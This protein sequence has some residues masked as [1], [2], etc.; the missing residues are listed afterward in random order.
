MPG[1]L[2]SKGARELAQLIRSGEVSSREVI[3]A[4][5]ERISEVNLRVNAVVEV[6]ETSA[7]AA[8]DAADSAVA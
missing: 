8:A 6:L 4:H 2:W 1:E 3:D 5:L 7:R